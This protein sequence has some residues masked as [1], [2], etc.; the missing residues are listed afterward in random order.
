METEALLKIAEFVYW[1]YAAIDFPIMWKEHWLVSRWW[2]ARSIQMDRVTMQAIFLHCYHV[3]LARDY[4]VD[5]ISVSF[6]FRCHFP[7]VSQRTACD[8]LHLVDSTLLWMNTSNVKP[9]RS[10]RNLLRAETLAMGI[11]EVAHHSL[12]CRLFLLWWRNVSEMCSV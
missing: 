1:L 12:S 7:I 4:L 8:R 3:L 10:P 11:E 6:W 9:V 5:S 2:Q